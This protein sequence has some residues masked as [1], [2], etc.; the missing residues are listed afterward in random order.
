MTK[1]AHKDENNF[2]LISY[3][4]NVYPEGKEKKSII[5]W[6]EGTIVRK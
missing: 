2:V 4:S 3:Y 6:G 1:H 5:D